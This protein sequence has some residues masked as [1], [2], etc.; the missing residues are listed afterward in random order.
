MYVYAGIGGVCG[1]S[2]EADDCGTLLW[3]TS[4]WQPAVVVPS[5]LQ[6]S[7]NL[8]FMC[9][10]YGIGGVLLKVDFT[11]NRWTVSIADQHKPAFGISSEQQ[12]PILYN[13]M[14]ISILPKDA[15]GNRG[16]IA[17]YSPSNIKTPVWTSAADER[18][19]DGP[20][21]V[22]NNLLFAFKSDGELYVYEFKQNG[23]Q[24]LKK[25]RI[26][27]GID[28]WGPLAYADGMLIVRDDHHVVCLK[29]N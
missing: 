15:L 8:L 28:A 3:E 17:C 19:G 12:T 13:N 1:V 4:R 26:L 7:D 11:G 24:L 23:L 25:Q 16:K 2:A 10:G 21:M 29:I 14:I 18:F 22:I 20:F 9:A 5:P 6:L 27:D